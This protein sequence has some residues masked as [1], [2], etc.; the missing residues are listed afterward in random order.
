[1]PKSTSQAKPK[2]S[3][4]APE[5]PKKRAPPVEPKPNKRRKVSEDPALED[6]EDSGDLSPAQKKATAR[7]KKSQVLMSDSSNE[8]GDGKGKQQKSSANAEAAAKDSESEMS[9]VFDE[10]PKPKKKRQN[11]D[12]GKA[13]DAPKTQKKKPSVSQEPPDPDV[14]EIKKLQGWLVKC[15]IRKL[16]G[17]ELASYDTSNAKIRHLKEMLSNAGMTGRYSNEKAASIR[18]TRELQADLEAV[19]EGNKSWGKA[20]ED[21]E[22]GEG[23]PRR[24]L[25]KGLQQ[26]NFLVDQSDG[27]DSS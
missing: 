23:R 19:Q 26:L 2:Q 1:V 17:K 14:E 12:K 27:D 16:W 3:K 21:A 18:E 22:E 10:D 5:K 11:A 6:E 4:S 7:S 8:G 9:V 25:A 24:R 15:G 20:A 13:K